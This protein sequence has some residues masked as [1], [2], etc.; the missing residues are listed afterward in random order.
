MRVW[1]GTKVQAVLWRMKV[2]VITGDRYWTNEEPIYR[3]LETLSAPDLVILGDCPRGVD[4]IALNACDDLSLAH[5]Q[6]EADWD[7]YGLGAGPIRNGVMLDHN[8]DELWWFH[9]RLSKS[10]GTKDCVIQAL[11]RD[12]SVLRGEHIGA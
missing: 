6:E 4:K 2:V 8:P 11:E 9:K 3:A 5:H 10:K 12:I 7:R 1:I